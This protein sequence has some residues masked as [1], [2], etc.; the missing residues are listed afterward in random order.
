MNPTVSLQLHSQFAQTDVELSLQQV[1]SCNCARHA[2]SYMHLCC[3]VAAAGLRTPSSPVSKYKSYTL[4]SV[5]LPIKPR[6]TNAS[7]LTA[8]RQRP[9]DR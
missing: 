9:S 6:R 3:R 8:E 5:A 2:A 7:S 1:S 4:V